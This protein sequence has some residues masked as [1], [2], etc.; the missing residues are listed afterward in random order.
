VPVETEFGRKRAVDQ[1]SCNLDTSCLKGFCPSFVTVHGAVPRKRDL[2]VVDGFVLPEP[3]IPPLRG[4]YAVLVTGVGGTGVVT[5]GALIGMA[6]HLENKGCS[7]LDM[8][9]LA[10]KNGAVVSHVRIAPLATDIRAIR[11]PAGGADLVLGCDMVVAASARALAAIDPGRT[12]VFV[13]SHETLTGAFTRDPDFSL[14]TRRLLQSISFRAGLDHTRVVEATRI[15]TALCGDAIGTN[16]FMLGLA[17]QAGAV[18]LSS[19]AILKAIEM[20]GV[21]VAMNKAAF[22]WGRRAAIEPGVVAALADEASGRP[23]APAVET[24]EDIVARR[25]TFLADYQ[26][27]AY[28]RR[29]EGLVA[30]VREAEAR[31]APGR[32]DVGEAVARNLF[33]LMAVKDEYEV[34]RLYTDGTFRRQLAREFA[35]W[36][37]LEFHLA[38]PLFAHRDEATG[39]PRKATY[40]PRV[41]GLFRAL[42]RMRH[43]RSTLLDPFRWTAERRMERRLLGDYLKVIDLIAGKLAPDNLLEAAALA[44]YPERIRGFGHVKAEAVL[45]A[46]PEI[47]ARR[48]AFLAGVSRVAE[49]AE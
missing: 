36:T 25:A 5:I 26:N 7:V 40:G 15:A 2:A 16:M 41:Q 28:A 39:R 14:P 8:T 19:R 48:E 30:R 43:L 44:S 45:K 35:G 1:S 6:A 24:L 32:S 31:V 38:P 49:A 13:N 47:A 27:A 9:G 34:A 37:K 3:R 20:N 46:V 11:V 22:A 12:Q 10:Q 21:D 17:W 29:Y 23:S 18:P 4:N 42:V 33:K